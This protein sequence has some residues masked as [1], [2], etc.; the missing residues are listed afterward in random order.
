MYGMKIRFVVG[1]GV[2]TDDPVALKAWH[3]E[4]KAHDDFLQLDALDT[5][6]AMTG[7]TNK[8]YRHVMNLPQ[9]YEYLVKIDDDMYLSLSHLSKAVEQWSDM[10]ADYVGCMT[11]PLTAPANVVSIKG[12]SRRRP[13]RMRD[14][15][16]I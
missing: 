11:H 16:V 8:M 14:V 5:Y 6:L 13:L 10:A 9:N 4:L 3:A 15:L 12:E 2:A 1:N 7:K